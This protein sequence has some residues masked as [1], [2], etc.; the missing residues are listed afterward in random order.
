MVDKNNN[1]SGISRR[2]FM[3]LT[4]AVGISGAV[5]PI[6]TNKVLA[7]DIEKESFNFSWHGPIKTKTVN[8]KLVSS[9]GYRPEFHDNSVA[10][11]M[12]EYVY[13][14]SRVKY[15]MVRKSYLEHGPGANREARGSEDFVRVSWDKATSL[16][17]GELKRVIKEHGNSAIL[18]S[19]SSA[20]LTSGRI[21][22]E[23]ACMSRLANLMGGF[24]DC[25]SEYSTGAA[26]TIMPHITGSTDV[27]AQQT[28]WKTVMENTEVIIFWAVDPMKTL[29]AG[30]SPNMGLGL[31]WMKKI[32]KTNKKFIMIDPQRSATA[33]DFGAEWIAPVPNTDVAMML[34]MAYALQ[35]TGLEN[36][37]FLDEYTSGYDKFL[38]YLL[39][40]T[41]G[42]PKTPE[43]AES[44]CQIKADKIREIAKLI[45]TKPSLLMSGWSMQRADHGEQPPWM[46]VT[47]ACMVGQI[48]LPGC[49]YS[50]G[51][52]YP[53]SGADLGQ[54]PT[55]PYLDYG[56]YPDDAPALIPAARTTDALLNPGEVIDYNGEKITYPDIKMIFNEYGNPQCRHQERS[57]MLTAWKKP[58]TIV[59]HEICWTASAWMSDIVLPVCTA[60]E[61]NDIDAC[62]VGSAITPIKAAIE[63]EFESK[64]P[65]TIFTEIA[66]AL[67]I[68]EE[69]TMGKTTMELINDSYDT[70]RKRAKNNGIEMPEFEEFWEKGEPLEFP[71]DEKD[72]GFVQHQEFREDPLLEPLGTATGKIEIYC[73]NIEKMGYDDCG[74]HPTWYEPFEYLGSPIAKK[75]PLHMVSPHPRYRLHSQYNQC[76]SLRDIYNVAGHE[77]VTINSKDAKLRNIK[78]GDVVR[79]FNDRGQTLAGARVTDNIRPDVIS[80]C[81]GGWYDPVE[82]GVPG[83]LCKHGHANTL[84]KDK[85]TSK[86]AQSCNSNTA[87]VQIEKYLGKV[88]PVTAF[89]PPKGA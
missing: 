20:Y 74:P 49:G 3:K 6:L 57:K 68:E 48:G 33:I 10:P 41:D 8:G 17:A 67:G 39:G 81:E 19:I 35:E 75:F 72:E 52:N 2:R 38:P 69:F 88:L 66:R 5:S 46:L 7:H 73:K 43:W 32:A 26:Q 65:F 89:D 78:D 1:Q 11:F 62:A 21:N 15:P 64:E 86:L 63:P 84:I 22:Y 45:A 58:D 82:R 18:T 87:L 50:M 79:I 25:V 59:T 14:K 9:E 85:P 27:Y 16:I 83:S 40:K 24:T 34:G 70:A 13:S 37:E 12:P 47:L 51:Q 31:D 28:S 44:I 60:L 76:Q 30:F 55:I 53:D 80:L 61:R 29:Q 23:G 4:G 77:P 42:T 71:I 54:A 56:D 36:K